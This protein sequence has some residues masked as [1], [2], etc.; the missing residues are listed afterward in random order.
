MRLPTGEGVTKATETRALSKAKFWRWTVLLLFDLCIISWVVG[1]PYAVELPPNYFPRRIERILSW[2][3]APVGTVSL[4][5]WASFCSL[6]ARIACSSM[7]WFYAAYAGGEKQRL[8]E[9]GNVEEVCMS[10]LAQ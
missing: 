9:E 5:W 10:V 7:Y 4:F 6:I 2:P 1:V 3:L 8:R